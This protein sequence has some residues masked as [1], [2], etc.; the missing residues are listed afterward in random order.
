M[1]PDDDARSGG[2]ETCARA[3]AGDVLSLDL[4]QIRVALRLAEVACLRATEATLAAQRL[5]VAMS[6]D[7]P[8]KEK[9]PPGG[10]IPDGREVP[11]PTKENA[12]TATA[13]VSAS[14]N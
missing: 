14:V 9:R 2:Q 13:N 5:A 8:P 7:R 12:H 3:S 6:R 10:S 4:E 1:E 11:L